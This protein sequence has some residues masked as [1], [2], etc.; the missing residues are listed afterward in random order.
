MEQ[1]NNNNWLLWVLLIFLPPFG[2]LYMWIAKKEFSQKKKK[3]LSI[4]FAIWFLFCLG[5]SGNKK[6][7]DNITENPPVVNEKNAVAVSNNEIKSEQSASTNDTQES[8]ES[9]ENI[10]TTE[11]SKTTSE[12]FLL[13][14]ELV[15]RDVLN[16]SRDTVI[17]KCAYIHI[18]DTELKEITSDLLKEFADTVVADSGYNWVSII[19]NSNKG[20]CFAGSDIIYVNYGKLDTDGSI[21]ET[22]GTCI[23]ESNGKYEYYTNSESE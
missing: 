4:V 12:N 23:L 14:C 3:T 15:E 11:E 13:N 20:L 5:V 16:G 1:K 8:T 6:S 7:T 18:T 22:Y 17:G 9:K 19:T 10:E 2:I 21:L